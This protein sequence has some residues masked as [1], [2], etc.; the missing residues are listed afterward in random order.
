[1]VAAVP[2]HRRPLAIIRNQ[3]TLGCLILELI[4]WSGADKREQ[5]NSHVSPLQG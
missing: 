2:H 3:L 1:M 5:F 4:G